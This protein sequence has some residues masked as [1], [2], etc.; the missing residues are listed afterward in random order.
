MHSHHGYHDWLSPSFGYSYHWYPTNY[1]N[2]YPWYYN[3]YQYYYYPYYQY[4]YPYSY[5]N[6]YWNW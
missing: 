4:Y 5:H 6:N 2:W 3:N 1:Y